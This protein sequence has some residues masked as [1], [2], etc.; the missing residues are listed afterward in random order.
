[1]KKISFF[2]T[3]MLLSG[4]YNLKRSSEIG[5]APALT[6]TQDPR[7]HKNYMPVNMPMPQGLQPSY[8]PNSLWR[9]GAKGFFKDQRASRVGDLI[10][11]DVAIQDKADLKNE[12]KQETTRTTNATVSSLVGIQSKFPAA[13]GTGI[14]NVIDA[15]SKPTSDGKS[16]SKRH[17]TIDLRVAAIV[18]QTLPNGN[19][20]ILGRQEVRMNFDI[21][22]IV[23]SGIVRPADIT[24]ENTISYEQIGE[25]RLSYGGRGEGMD[26]Q[27]VPYGQQLANNLLPF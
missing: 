6:P 10:L 19:L 9:V 16:T 24:A 18:T 12:T 27:K 4:C 11:V 20:V 22:E 5:T 7:A 26:M 25:A 2:L 17:E 23:I 13:M 15:E 8:P 21:R 1:M 14:G 3:A